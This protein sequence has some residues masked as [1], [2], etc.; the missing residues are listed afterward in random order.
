MGWSACR[1][2]VG[3][4]GERKTRAERV[5]EEEEDALKVTFPGKVGGG[6]VEER[7]RKGQQ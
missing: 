2:R 4:G 3:N 7:G 1:A 5:E 6:G